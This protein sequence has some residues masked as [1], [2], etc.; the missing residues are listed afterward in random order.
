MEEKG[1]AN[2]KELHSK[3]SVTVRGQSSLSLYVTEFVWML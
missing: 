2:A 3:L 1:E